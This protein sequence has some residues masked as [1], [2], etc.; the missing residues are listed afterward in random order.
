MERKCTVLRKEES[1]VKRTNTKIII[2]W[3]I[4]V[5]ADGS[6]RLERGEC[7]LGFVRYLY[8]SVAV[9]LDYFVQNYNLL[10]SF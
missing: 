4:F 1:K 7:W 3:F 5:S 10:A 9:E 6:W 8:V 2:I